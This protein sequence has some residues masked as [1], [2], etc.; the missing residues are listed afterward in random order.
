MRA[1]GTFKLPGG[2]ICDAG[3]AGDRLD[4]PRASR[5]LIVDMPAATAAATNGITMPLAAEEF[6]INAFAIKGAD[7]RIAANKRFI[8]ANNIMMLAARSDGSA[9][10]I[11]I[12]VSAELVN[13]MLNMATSNA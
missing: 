11:C 9:S 3:N 12:K 10:E 2:R 4:E 6:V 1:V 7:T 5:P 8:T 13:N